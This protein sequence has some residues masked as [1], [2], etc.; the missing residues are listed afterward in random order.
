MKSLYESIL[1]STKSGLSALPIQFS[2]VYTSNEFDELITDYCKYFGA[3]NSEY[4]VKVLEHF[5][6]NLKKQDDKAT[7]QFAKDKHLVNK[8]KK[9]EESDAYMYM[10]KQKYPLLLK[11][12]V[13]EFNGW[14]N[15]TLYSYYPYKKYVEK[16]FKFYTIEQNILQ[17][18]N[19]V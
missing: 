6:K 13:G 19:L 8:I 12:T 11:E 5:C 2:R 17:S 3:N 16:S 1:G 18:Y 10:S 4:I 15:S 14:G 7:L 9:V